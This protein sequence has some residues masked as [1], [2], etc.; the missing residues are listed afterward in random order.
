MS[1]YEA[2]QSYIGRKRSLGV[3]FEKAAMNLRAFSK[4]MGD[5]PLDT[6]TPGQIL[7]FLNG[8]RSS[9]I[10]WRVK[11]SL[12]RHFFEY[13]AAR[14]MLQASPMPRIRPP[15]QQT[16]VPYIYKK[17]EI[18]SL[19][20][21][22]RTCQKFRGCCIDATTLRMLVLFLYATGVLVGEVLRLSRADVDLK[23]GL[24]TVREGRFSRRRCIPTGQTCVR[25]SSGICVGRNARN[26][27][28]RTCLRARTGAPSKHE[29]SVSLLKGCAVWREFDAMTVLFISPACTTC[30]TPLPCIGLRRGLSKART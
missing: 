22:A 10:T 25:G 19:L 14:G 24:I 5:V 26:P 13:W 8:S 7:A 9:T 16:F 18:R 28:L 6:I 27:T 2:V 21:K 20:R 30:D 3:A 15:V 17:S 4:R 11:F 29:S 12:L 23:A 1:L